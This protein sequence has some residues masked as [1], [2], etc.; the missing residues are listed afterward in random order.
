L[1]PGGGTAL[2]EDIFY[3]NNLVEDS[4]VGIEIG[5]HSVCVLLRGNTS[6]EVARPVVDH[7]Q[8]AAQIP[9]GAE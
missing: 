2:A 7:R 8:T 1:T 4:L 6:T 3:E 9:V 5:A